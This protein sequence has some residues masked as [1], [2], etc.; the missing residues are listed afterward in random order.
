MTVSS[1]SLNISTPSEPIMSG[2][3]FYQLEEEALFVQ[4]GLFTNNRRFYSYLEAAGLTLDFD[5]QGRLIFVEVDIPRNQWVI[6]P[7]L[8]VPRVVEP[9]DIRWLN[10]RDTIRQPSFQTNDRRDLL[11]LSFGQS[12]Q[13]LSFYAADSI[14]VQTDLF[15]T[16]MALWVSDIRDDLAG[17]KIR[18]FRKHS[19]AKQSYY[20]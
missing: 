6:Q 10:F 5:R 7:E 19:R 15:H 4:I 13:L 11:K 8:V 12:A 3:G 20:S 9:A 1:I 14:V 17:R 2:R 18:T 16:L